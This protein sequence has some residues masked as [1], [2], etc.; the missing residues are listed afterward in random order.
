M[1][2]PDFV[3]ERR[4]DAIMHVAG[5]DEIKT[6]EVLADGFF[7]EEGRGVDENDF[8]F[9]AGEFFERIGDFREDGV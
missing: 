7:S 4:H 3:K 6:L 1:A 8:R 9:V 5:D 2:A